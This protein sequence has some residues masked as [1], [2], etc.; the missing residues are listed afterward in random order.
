MSTTKDVQRTKLT[1]KGYT[2]TLQEQEKKHWTA[3]GGGSG[4]ANDV[5]AKA[6]KSLGY[7][8][9]IND[10]RAAR[11]KAAGGEQAYWSNLP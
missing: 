9:S 3:V 6:L 8:G 7:S 2:G 5:E 11:N 1:A 10:M 4:A